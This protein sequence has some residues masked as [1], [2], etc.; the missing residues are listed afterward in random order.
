MIYN[1]AKLDDLARVRGQVEDLCTRHGCDSVTWYPTSVEDP[2]VGQARQSLKEGA[3]VVCALGG[4]GT[5]RSVASVLA[6]TDV[7]LGLLPGGTGNLLARNLGV[8]TD[9]LPAALRTV[10]DGAERRI[11]VG[12][13]AWDDG[14]EQVF[15]VMAGVGAD[16]S[17][18]EHADE[19]VKSAVGWPAYLISGVRALFDPGFSVRVATGGRVVSRRRARTLLIGNCGDLP[20]GVRLLPD[21]RI[22][23]G[24]LDAVV[25]A[26]QGVLGWLA[27][28]REVVLARGHRDGQAIRRLRA[29]RFAV[30][31]RHS[32]PAQL[33]GDP[34][35][36]ATAIQA[37]VR[38]DALR[39]RVPASETGAAA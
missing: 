8:P 17:M 16:A 2:G 11:D 20:G 15:L 13:V 21:A 10:L 25:L 36:R 34:A 32:V 7:A 9:D 35:G 39:V 4:D 19:R 5:V 29:D 28:L 26:P 23:D 38:P 31:L 27:V 18:M 22:D 12:L 33:D 30:T 14:P 1:P 3:T 24:R 37:R 6:G